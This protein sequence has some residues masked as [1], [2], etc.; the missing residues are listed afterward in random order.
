MEKDNYKA[1]LLSEFGAI[2]QKSRVERGFTQ[3]G[4]SELA[5]ITD[6]YLR[7]LECGTSTATWVI[8]LKLCTILNIDIPELQKKYILPE[9]P[10]SDAIEEHHTFDP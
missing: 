1:A 3:E 9:Y 5:G 2:I 4:L 7:N 8:W 6:V 10:K